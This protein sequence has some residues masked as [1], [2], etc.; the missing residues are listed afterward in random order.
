MERRL[1]FICLNP[2][3]TIWQHLP[4]AHSSSSTALPSGL[5]TSSPHSLLLPTFLL[6]PQFIR[7]PLLVCIFYNPP[8]LLPSVD[9]WKAIMQRVCTSVCVCECV[10]SRSMGTG[11]FGCQLQSALTCASNV[12]YCPNTSLEEHLRRPLKFKAIYHNLPPPL[13]PPPSVSHLPSLPSPSPYAVTYF[14]LLCSSFYSSAS[15]IRPPSF[16]WIKI[17]MRL[18]GTALICWLQ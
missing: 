6:H 10:C 4:L 14:L 1:H 2:T 5:N 12:V 7:S 11:L 13:P 3:L 18:I 16:P 17:Q 15:T 9:F 8:C